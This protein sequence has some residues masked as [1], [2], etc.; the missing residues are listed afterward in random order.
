MDSN[1]S[2]CLFD[3]HKIIADN[4]SLEIIIN[5][6]CKAYN[7]EELDEDTLQ[8]TDY[9]VWEE[10]FLKSD[11]LK[12]YE[13]FWLNKFEVQD[14][15]PLNLP[16]DYPLSDIKAYKGKTTHIDLTK[17]TFKILENLAE[18][19]NITN[20]SI[21]LATL[22][23][24]LYKYTNRYDIIIGLPTSS[25]TFK[26]LKNV[27]GLFDNNLV[28]NKNIEPNLKFIDFVKSVDEDI[29]SGFSNQPYPFEILQK[30]LNL[31]SVNPLLDIMFTYQDTQNN[32]FTNNTI[33][34][35]LNKN[36]ENSKFNLYF[37]ISP[38]QNRLILEFN[39]N[40][41]RLSTAKSLL[42]HYLFILKQVMLNFETKLC[43]FEMVT[44]EETRLLEKFNNTPCSF[45]IL[46]NASFEPISIN[47]IPSFS[48]T[49]GSGV[50]ST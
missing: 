5:D 49:S 36:G 7:G 48:A 8:Y 20:S 33:A 21:F 40:L 6:F 11:K 45:Y 10:G 1:L 39:L 19:Y 35:I 15:T 27:I 4:S 34:K 18:K 24:L 16:Y 44:P 47:I 46:S 37:K 29:T 25:R 32:D 30:N 28:L 50:I 42:S 38:T 43:D 41:F 23:I 12:V 13:K 14:F 9:A 2:L 17:K 3:T 31:S 26:E 22:Y